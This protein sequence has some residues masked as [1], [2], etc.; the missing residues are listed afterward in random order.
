MNTKEQERTLVLVALT[1]GVLGLLALYAPRALAPGQATPLSGTPVK[2][3]QTAQP[4]STTQAGNT[5]A[6]DMATPTLE[7]EVTITFPTT[8]GLPTPVPI[9]DPP[10]FSTLPKPPQAASLVQPESTINIVLLGTDRRSGEKVAR[11][12]TIILVAIDPSVPTVNAVSIPRDLYV[13]IPSQGYERINTA[14]MYGV[15][16]NY[17]GGGMGLVKA[18]ILYNFGI[19]VHYGA[20][21]DFEGFKAM[22]DAVGGVDVLVDAPLYDSYPDESEPGGWAHIMLDPGIHHMDGSLALKYVRSRKTT[23]DFD[24][25]RRQ[26][27]VLRALYDQVLGPQVYKNLPAAWKA[28]QQYLETDLDFNTV[29]YLAGIARRL[30]HRLIK[31][32][33]VEAYDV[34][35]P[36]T[37]PSNDAVLR[38]YPE[39]FQ[40]FIEEAFTPALSSRLERPAPRV[41][42]FDN[43]G[44]FNCGVLLRDQLALRGFDVVWV[45]ADPSIARTE[46]ID[47][48]TTSK[49]S[50][51][52]KLQKIIGTWVERVVSM[53]QDELTRE[54]EFDVNLGPGFGLCRQR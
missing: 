32:R 41:R 53:P 39:R 2:T 14:Y 36:W 16:H 9:Y 7:L 10:V 48:T 40:A 26:Q 46:I 18:T 13:W 25:N 34:V 50:A 12:D 15:L 19:P 24:R 54:V 43:S 35:Y 11:T 37:T 27:Q 20:L 4:A 6:V 3:P 21:M 52:P 23:S 49:G 31:S 33:M 28:A 42:I 1:L 22:I 38:P 29:L 17:P 45:F 8:I 30:D 47:Y 44:T 51:L 5:P